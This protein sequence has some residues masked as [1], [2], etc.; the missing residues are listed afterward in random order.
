M[1][2]IEN[3]KEILMSINKNKINSLNFQKLIDEV[4]VALLEEKTEYLYKN[5]LISKEYYDLVN[6]VIGAF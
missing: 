1:N 2:R 4:N 6:D 5:G 3:I